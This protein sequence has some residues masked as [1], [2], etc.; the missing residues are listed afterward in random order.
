MVGFVDTS[1]TRDEELDPAVTGEVLAIYVSPRYW[2]QGF[3]KALMEAAENQLSEDGFMTAML[4]VLAENH[5]A[6]RFYESGG[7]Q[8]DGATKMDEFGGNPI[9]EVRYL[10]NLS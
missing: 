9:L 6:R 5:R 8:R 10:K 7:W 4:W 2:G 3:G 1:E